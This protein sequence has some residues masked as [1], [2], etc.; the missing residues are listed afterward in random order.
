MRYYVNDT[1]ILII[2]IKFIIKYNKYTMIEP[3]LPIATEIAHSQLVVVIAEPVSNEI[4]SRHNIYM[5]NSR[6]ISVML[7]ITT[8]L[9]ILYVLYI[10]PM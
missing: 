6:E 5:V 7:T 9:A 4:I 1:K 3:E 10:L 2:F 8:I